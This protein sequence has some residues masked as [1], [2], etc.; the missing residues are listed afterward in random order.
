MQAAMVLLFWSCLWAFFSKAWPSLWKVCAALVFVWI[1]ARYSTLV[2]DLRFANTAM[3]MAGIFLIAYVRTNIAVVIGLLYVP[4]LLVMM[5]SYFGIGDQQLAWNMAEIALWLQ[6]LI[7][8]TGTRDGGFRQFHFRRWRDRSRAGFATDGAGIS[9][10][11]KR[12]F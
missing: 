12:A 1:A 3:F 8:Y 5:P 2:G 4:R 11:Q 7:L 9:W 10:F 6:Y